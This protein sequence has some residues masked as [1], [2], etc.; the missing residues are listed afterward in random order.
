M[1]CLLKTVLMFYSFEH[2]I[3]LIYVNHFF[4]E[5]RC[6]PEKKNA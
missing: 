3:T 6:H 4:K 5:S 1:N 2:N